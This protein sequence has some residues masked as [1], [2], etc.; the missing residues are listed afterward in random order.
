MET[1]ARISTESYRQILKSTSILGISSVINIFLRT[2]R[3]KFLAVLLGPSGIGLMSIYNSIT[4]MAVST[5]GLGIDSSGVRQIAAAASSGDEKQIAYTIYALRRVS[6][7]LGLIGMLLLILLSAPICHI[8]FKSTEYLPEIIL[9]SIIILLETVMNAEISLIQGMRKISDLAKI[10]IFSAFFG[11]IFSVPILYVWGKKGIVPFLI[12]ASVSNIFT[13]WWYARKIKISPIQM[14]WT[15]FWLQVKPMVKLG[16]A[17]MVGALIAKGTLYLAYVFISRQL[18]LEAVGLYQ[19]AGV[20]SFLY[21]GFILNA[22]VKDYLPRLAAFADNNIA[23][24]ELINQQTEIG[25]LLAGPGILAT[26]TFAPLVIQIFYTYKFI[27]SYEVL[28][29]QI[30]G[31]IIQVVSWPMFLIFQ[32]RDQGKLIMVTEL[33]K[34]IVFIVFLWLGISYYGL[35][36][37]GMAY[38]GMCIIHC[39]VVYRV[40]NGLSGFAWSGKN[41]KI[42]LLIIPAICIIFISRFYLNS[43]WCMI[44]G[45]IISLWF[46]FYS[47]KSLI[48][49]LNPIGFVPFLIKVKDR[50]GNRF[51]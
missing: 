18:G 32:A 21:V 49:I 34:N 37:A 44:I 46:A 24:N 36:G 7:F 51:K 2:I 25:I 11:L 43:L 45:S 22:M 28:R 40:T 31:I 42:I 41:I 16:F 4:E 30:L 39:Y 15:V 6:L 19:A 8:S 12:V 1:K 23:T 17:I 29:W 13:A 5:T 26:L 14:N 38:L 27:A 47:L 20:L 9:L 50:F 3:T 10:N 48:N 35:N 33:L